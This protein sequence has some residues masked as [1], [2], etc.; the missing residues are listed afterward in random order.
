[1]VNIII[2]ISKYLLIALMA[3]YTYQCLRCLHIRMSIRKRILIRQNE[4]MFAIHFIA[5]LILYLKTNEKKMLM[6][7]E[8]RWYSF[9]QFS[10]YIH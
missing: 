3:G 7:M 2:E 1:M 4:L 5:F 8:D 10:S 9:W 6:F